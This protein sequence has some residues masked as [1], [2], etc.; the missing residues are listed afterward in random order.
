MAVEIV[1][2]G[3]AKTCR[4]SILMSFSQIFDPF[5]DLSGGTLES[6]GIAGRLNGSNEP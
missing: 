4:V 1:L 6:S 2:T 5:S 3:V